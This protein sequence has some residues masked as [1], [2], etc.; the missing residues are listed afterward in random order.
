MQIQAYF[1]NYKNKIEPLARS[2]LREWQ[3]KGKQE[4]EVVGEMMARFGDFFPKGKQ[5]RGALTVFGYELAGGKENDD[6]LRASLAVELLH[7]SLLIADDIFDGDDWRRGELSFHRQWE[8]QITGKSKVVKQTYGRNMAFNTAIT[9][10]YLAPLIL[11][12][13]QFSLEIKNQALNYFFEKGI[14]TCWGEGLDIA[15]SYLPVR[16]KRQAAR[17]IH[18]L[19]TVEYSGVLPFHLGAVLYGNQDEE[20]LANLDE[21]GRCMGRAFQ[22]QDDIIGCFGDQKI[23][24]KRNDTD[25][26]EGRWTYLVELLYIQLSYAK[27][28]ELLQLLDK[29]SRNKE[30]IL[31]IKQMM[32]DYKIKELAQKKAQSYIAKGKKLIPQITTDAV[33]G[34]K[35]ASLLHLMLNRQ[36]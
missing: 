35:M 16:Q 2:F 36:K 22:I 8:E 28:A 11:A 14:K 15:S 7:A 26:I 25:L 31:L 34:E 5:Y 17:T 19:K 6:I 13:T 29:S 21:F 9:G 18:D 1:E 20:F 32:L 12:K 24:G 10:I 30:D 27:K 23:S 4:A 3:E 33:L